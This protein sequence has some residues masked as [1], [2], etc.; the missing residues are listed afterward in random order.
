MTKK[1]SAKRSK[2]PAGIAQDDMD[3]R[4]LPKF[5]FRTPSSSRA[6]ACHMDDTIEVRAATE[7]AARKLAMDRRWAHRPSFGHP[8]EGRGLILVSGPAQ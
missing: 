2:Q 4:G 8:Y 3:K 6:A 7:A 1:S 5:I